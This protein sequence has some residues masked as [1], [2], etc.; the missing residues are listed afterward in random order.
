MSVSIVSFGQSTKDRIV[1][2]R[3]RGV[4][5]ADI[6]LTP[7]N[8]LKALTPIAEVKGVKNNETSTLFIPEKYL[9]GEFVL[10]INYRAKESDSPYPSERYIYVYKQDIEL[11]GNP[12]YIND[13]DSTKFSSGET[14]N[15]V[16]GT[17]TLENGLK[18]SQLELLRQL[19][20]NYDN[21]NSAF[22]T[23]T[24]KEF[25]QRR[26]DYNDWLSKQS[27]THKDLFVSRLF[28]FKYIPSIR[29]TEDKNAQ[30]VRYS[31]NY[32]EGIDLTDTLI[33][34]SRELNQ[35]MSD[36]MGLYG[37]QS[38]TPELRDSLF[39]MAGSIACEKASE[40]H[41]KVYGWMTDYFYNGYETYSINRGMHMLQKHIN[42]PNC[43]T[44]KKQQINK[45]L[46]GMKDLIPGTMAP[47]FI[48]PVNANDNF[49]FHKW[50][51]KAPYKLLVF[52]S[53]DCANCILF[54]NELKQWYS[55]PENKK[56]LDIIAVSLD[57]TGS[58]V[59]KWEA[60]K[61][62][63]PGWQHLR[64]ME[65]VNSPVANSYS[66]LSTPA[67]YLV[68]NKNNIIKAVPVDLNQLKEEIKD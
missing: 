61:I 48:L 6:S 30:L 26:I 27:K 51:S 5:D 12:P 54:A 17:F 1:K 14:E 20:L 44:A 39:T 21:R 3:L 40:G 65:G 24:V 57:A 11:S 25:E 7:F 33:L 32:F 37:M 53:A 66:I 49:N 2:I 59:Q 55:I 22:Y 43:L 63:F 10:R 64:A 13:S 42:N 35:F 4:F 8:G 47:D 45:R 31:K 34:R 15:T 52:W 60:A 58:E 29:W 62:E 19:L 28:Q 18:R 16:Y 38:T 68:K 46:A 56:K 50:K 23:Q 41:P 67:M 36:Y 9:P